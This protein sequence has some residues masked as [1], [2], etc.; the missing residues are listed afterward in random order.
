MGLNSHLVA[1]EVVGKRKH[2]L[3]HRWRGLEELIFEPTVRE[4]VGEKNFGFFKIFLSQ[5]NTAV[6]DAVLECEEHLSFG[7]TM[8]IATGLRDRLGNVHM[9]RELQTQIGRERSVCLVGGQLGELGF[10]CGYSLHLA[11]VC[12]N[13]GGLPL[14]EGENNR[15]WWL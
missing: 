15:L 2:E 13:G 4:K 8:S 10:L 11:L 9:R 14:L 1:D 12:R 7:L 5:G 3:R 6:E